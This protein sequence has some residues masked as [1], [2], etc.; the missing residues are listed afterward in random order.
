VDWNGG[1]VP[2]ADEQSRDIIRSAQRNLLRD[3]I[4][5]LQPGSVVFLTGPSY[6]FDLKA[7]FEGVGFNPVDNSPTLARFVHRHLPH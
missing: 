3:E 7:E 5:I 2:K 4:A 6:D 1:S